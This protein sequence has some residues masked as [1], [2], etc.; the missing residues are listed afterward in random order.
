LG[1]NLG[2]C[3]ENS[4]TKDLSYDINCLCYSESLIACLPQSLLWHLFRIYYPLE[5][6]PVVISFRNCGEITKI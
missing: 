6:K 1:L 4:V 5:Y 2:F 3:D